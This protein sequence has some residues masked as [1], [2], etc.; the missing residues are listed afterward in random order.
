MKPVYQ[1]INVDLSITGEAIRSNEEITLGDLYEVNLNGHRLDLSENTEA[2]KVLRHF[3]LSV[4][5]EF[6]DGEWTGPHD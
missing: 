3:L 4:F 6:E 5:N 2:N 1:T